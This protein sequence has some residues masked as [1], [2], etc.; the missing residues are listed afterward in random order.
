MHGKSIWSHFLNHGSIFLR[1]MIPCYR[2]APMLVFILLSSFLSYRVR[3]MDLS[4]SLLHFILLFV[5]LSVI[6]LISSG[7][8][9]GQKLPPGTMGWPIIGET[10]EFFITATRGTPEKFITDRMNKYSPKIFKTSLLGKKMAV[11]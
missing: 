10:L 11:M 1:Y 5:T 9:A 2:V 3:N 4:S 8:S 6:F 7:K